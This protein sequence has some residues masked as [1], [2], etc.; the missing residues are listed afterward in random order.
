MR[1]APFSQLPRV[2]S[3]ADSVRLAVPEK[4]FGL[5]LI[6]G[7]FDRCGKTVLASS[8]TGGASP[9]FPLGRGAN[10]ERRLYETQ[11]QKSV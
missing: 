2:R 9:L 10:N 11:C 3:A 1:G 5:A 6:L 8:A 4:T 7:F